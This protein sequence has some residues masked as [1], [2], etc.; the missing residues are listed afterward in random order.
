MPHFYSYRVQSALCGGP[1][2]TTR[3][4]AEPELVSSFDV[5]IKVVCIAAFTFQCQED[6]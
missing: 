5:Y 1:N 2:K 6:Y 3:I 4:K